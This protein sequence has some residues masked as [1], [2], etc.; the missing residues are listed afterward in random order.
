MYTYRIVLD[1]YDS[2][3]TV[4]GA[5]VV[6]YSYGVNREAALRRLGTICIASD[7]TVSDGIRPWVGVNN[8]PTGTGMARFLPE[9][10]VISVRSVPT[11]AIARVI[12]E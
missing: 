10:E 5:R 9:W 11:T 6:T 1:A 3:S 4:S 8:L 7:G 2:R 12:A